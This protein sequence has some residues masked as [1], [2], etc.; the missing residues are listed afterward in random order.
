MEHV[1]SLERKMTAHPHDVVKVRR[2]VL[3][4]K[5]AIPGLVPIQMVPFSRT[6]ERVSQRS[7]EDISLKFDV[8][9]SSCTERAENPVPREGLYKAR[10]HKRREVMNCSP[11]QHHVLL[12][13]PTGS[14]CDLLSTP[15]I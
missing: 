15:S 12:D 4:A 13:S 2:Y 3:L 8:I 14:S 6:R 11:W 9:G 1:L 10:R 7:V 5:R